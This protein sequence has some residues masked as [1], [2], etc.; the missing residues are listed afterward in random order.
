MANPLF[1]HVGHILPMGYADLTADDPDPLPN[2]VIGSRKYAKGQLGFVR[3]DFGVRIFRYMHNKQGSATTAGVPYVRA[4]EVT[5]TAGSGSTTTVLKKTSGF[6]ANALIGRLLYFKT[7][8]V[9]P[10]A[11]PEGEV[12]PIVAN[13]A[14]SVTVDENY[15][16]SAAANS[17]DTYEIHSIYDFIVTAGGEN[18]VDVFGLS[19]SPISDGNWGVVQQ[20]GYCPGAVVSAAAIAKGATVVTTSTPGVGNGAA[21]ASKL[22]VGWAPIGVNSTNSGKMLVF[23]NV[24]APFG[25]GTAS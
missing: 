16:F 23:M 10:G 9:T 14:N 21:S 17:G 11:A 7:N 5:S 13:D 19:V 3:D 4:A 18:A 8:S 24:Y 25:P 6:T 2:G 20:Y 1:L 15:P 22:W 12:A